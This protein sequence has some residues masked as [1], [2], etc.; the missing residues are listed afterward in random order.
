MKS[1][2]KIL[3]AALL[4]PAFAA[5]HADEVSPYSSRGLGSLNDN[6]TSTQRSMGG[7]GIA[8]QSRSKINLKNPASF[9]AIDSMTFLFDMGANAGVLHTSDG[10]MKSRE[11]LGG[12]D[13]LTMQV[14]LGKW[15]G[16]SLGLMPFSSVG[17]TFGSKSDSQS[18]EYNGNGGISQLY[19][20]WAARPVKGLS[21]GVSASYLFGNIVNTNYV[22]AGTSSTVFESVLKVR[23]YQLQF[24]AQYGV[25]ITRNHR[26]SLG[27]TYSPAHALHGDGYGTKYDPTAQ[28]GN[29][30]E[31]GNTKLQHRFALPW[32]SG[33]GIAYS[34][35]NRL[36][37][38]VDY[39]LQNWSNARF[40]GIEDFTPAQKFN[41]R[42]MLN[43]GAEFTPATRGNYFKRMTYR[44]GGHMGQDYVTVGQGNNKV[45]EYGASC[46][47]GF[48]TSTRTT[49]NLGFEYLHR[50]SQPTATVA[51]NYFMVTVG[52]ALNEIWF[53]PSKIR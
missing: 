40:D 24:G 8:V 27:V 37:L 42:S 7:A 29:P 6:A 3:A 47:F 16:A 44:V 21:L 41:N 36:T 46:G 11:P 13:Y 20:G 28:N 26:V 25:N 10:S 43:F 49:V 38:A 30:Q 12:L 52:V 19:L 9:A 23:D 4:L 53:V 22:K 15:M 45:G 18:V 2:R 33:A 39:S 32:M 34:W 48:P 51:E 35:Q 1:L 17:Y 50:E 5:V 31:I 14:P